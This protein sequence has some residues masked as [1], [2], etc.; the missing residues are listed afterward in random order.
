M[1]LSTHMCVYIRSIYIILCINVVDLSA[2]LT[3]CYNCDTDTNLI[4]DWPLDKGVHPIRYKHG[5]LIVIT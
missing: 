5:G 2:F 3:L 1:P 4:T